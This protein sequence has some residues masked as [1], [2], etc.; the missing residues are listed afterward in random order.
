[1]EKI[2]DLNDVLLY[3]NNFKHDN[4]EKRTTES[5]FNDAKEIVINE[6]L[7]FNKFSSIKFNENRFSILKN[8]VTRRINELT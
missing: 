8:A 2:F 4:I 3:I 7:K 6:Y 1:M 5:K